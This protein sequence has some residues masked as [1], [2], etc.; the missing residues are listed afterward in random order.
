M[1]HKNKPFFNIIPNIIGVISLICI[2]LFNGVVI[3]EELVFKLISS[4]VVLGVF[5]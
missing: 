3:F 2:F 5:I 1:S 4:T